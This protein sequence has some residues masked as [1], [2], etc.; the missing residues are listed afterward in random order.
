MFKYRVPKAILLTVPY[1][2]THFARSLFSIVDP[3]SIHDVPSAHWLD[4]NVR[5]L[6]D[7]IIRRKLV[8]TARDPYLTAIRS[9]QT[10][11]ED[12][13]TF[14]AQSWETCFEAI[15]VA[16]HF[17]L[18]IG[19]QKERRLKHALAAINFIGSECEAHNEQQVAAFVDAW[20]P[21]NESQSKYKTEYLETGNLPDE[22]DWSLLDEASEWYNAL[23]TNAK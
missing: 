12:P 20:L 18:D 3:L 14:I 13:I 21:E 4:G 9:I 8:I 10:G 11:H 7:K 17:I 2:G 16:D 22:Y 15:Q 5:E 23:L 1:T 6:W 19:C